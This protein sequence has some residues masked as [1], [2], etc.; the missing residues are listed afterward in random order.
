MIM[1]KIFLILTLILF[2]VS[3]VHAYDPLLI[4]SG[5]P[6]AGGAPACEYTTVDFTSP[7][8]TEMDAE[9]DINITS[10]TVTWTS[11][12]SDT[13][14]YVYYDYG[15][16]YFNT[17]LTVRMQLNY[18][19]SDDNALVGYYALSNM[20]STGTNDTGDG[21]TIRVYESASADYIEIRLRENGS[22]TDE[23]WWNGVI[24]NG[25]SPYYLT[26]MR[27]DDAGTNSTGLW[28]LYICTTA[29][30]V[31]GVN[32]QDTLVINSAAGEQNDFRYMYTVR[33]YSG[34]GG[35][36][37]SGSIVN[38]EWKECLD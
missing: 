12:D 28:T 32:L 20:V 11:M 2:M 34:S 24:E 25:G 9:S 26:L 18:V 13:T 10:S 8:W 35:R 14:S 33:S 5:M 37:N 19:R 22:N 6:A 7:A 3:Q 36:Y 1:K 4:F 23:D 38:L 29:Y 17:D 31:D 16:G 15:A 21:F 27:D 30:C